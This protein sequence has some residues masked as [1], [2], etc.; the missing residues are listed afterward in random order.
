[1]RPTKSNEGKIRMI[2]E[3]NTIDWLWGKNAVFEALKANR[4]ISRIYLEDG[5]KEAYRSEVIKYCRDR[6]IPYSFVDKKQLTYMIK[7][8]SHQGIL[9]QTA[10]K[11]YIAWEALVEDI[12]QKTEEP[13]LILLDEVEDPQN[14][15]AIIRCAD[16]L[17]ANGVVITKNRSVPLTTSVARASAGALEYVPVA[18]VANLA[19]TMERLKKMGFWLVGA[20]VTGV[21][22]LYEQNLRGALAIVLG[23][24]GKGLS[25]LVR[26][27]CDFTI[28]IPMLGNINS[29]NVAASA[30]VVLYEALRQRKT[31]LP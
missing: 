5:A 30:A 9:A 29:L 21:R 8:D 6:G 1:M 14:L 16:A 4:P 11:E 2:K 3:T 13:L 10:P 20:D 12:K 28:S 22:P 17:G 27:K 19:Q 7:S 24:E 31:I 23:G 26:E 15:G 25:R 18:R